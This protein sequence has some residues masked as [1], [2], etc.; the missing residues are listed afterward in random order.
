MTV[1][2]ELSHF[3]WGHAAAEIQVPDSPASRIKLLRL[4]NRRATLKG[5]EQMVVILQYH[6]GMTTWTWI[7]LSLHTFYRYIM[8]CV[9]P[10]VW[11]Q[12]HD[13]CV[14]FV[15]PHCFLCSCA[16]LPDLALNGSS[17]FS[18]PYTDRCTSTSAS[19]LQRAPESD[20][21]FRRPSHI[22]HPAVTFYAS[23]LRCCQASRPRHWEASCVL[24]AC[25]AGAWPVTSPCPS[26]RGP[27]RGGEAVTVMRGEV[28]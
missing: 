11:D 13:H 19:A 22:H 18:E 17:L 2:F 21:P 8:G 12:G 7:V 9:G 24:Q 6:P 10:K 1:T 3:G 15:K 14:R 5:R 4:R 23:T 20:T 28:S 26:S 27:P 25:Y 16:F